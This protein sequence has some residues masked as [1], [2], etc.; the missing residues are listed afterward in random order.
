MLGRGNVDK[1]NNSRGRAPSTGWLRRAAST[2]SPLDDFFFEIEAHPYYLFYY[3]F[4]VTLFFFSKQQEWSAAQA[5]DSAAPPYFESSGNMEIDGD[6]AKASSGLAAPFAAAPPLSTSYEARLE[7]DAAASVASDARAAAD[8]GRLALLLSKAGQ[9]AF[10]RRALGNAGKRRPVSGGS[11]SGGGSGGE[12]GGVAPPPFHTRA[13]FETLAHAFVVVRPPREPESL[14]V[15]DAGFRDAVTVVSPPPRL[16]KVLDALPRVFVGCAARLDKAVR[17]VASETR[18]A[19]EAEGRP[20]P[21]SRSTRAL[22]SKWMPQGAGTVVAERPPSEGE[23]GP[24]C[25]APSSSGGGGAAAAMGLSPPTSP[26]CAAGCCSPFDDAYRRG[27]PQSQDRRG[28]SVAASP[29]GP[30]ACSAA[31]AAA[32][33]AG[34]PPTALGG[35][36]NN[37]SE[38]PSTPPIALVAPPLVAR[39]SVSLLSSSLARASASTS[40]AAATA[41]KASAAAFDEMR[42]VRR[43]SW[44]PAT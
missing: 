4:H 38:N 23:R 43:A 36:G 27:A 40:S 1:K 3:L 44:A 12:G 5:D 29:E 14:V 18:L 26:A 13:I 11:S 22:L 21:P 42:P 7:H 28:C 39:L 41:A 25:G 34:V 37:S 9:D 17:L 20:L 19:L 6:A 8:P 16:A 15:V 10:V 32:A 31:A 2:P 35:G 30:L 24:S 33:A